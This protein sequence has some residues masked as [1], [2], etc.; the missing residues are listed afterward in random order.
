M[1]LWTDSGKTSNSS[2]GGVISRGVV[3]TMKD[4]TANEIW[5]YVVTKGFPRAKY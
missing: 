3:D 4:G 2:L 1:L 5:C